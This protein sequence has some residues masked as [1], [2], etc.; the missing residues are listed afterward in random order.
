MLFTALWLAAQV[1]QPQPTWRPIEGF[2]DLAGFDKVEH[3][4]ANVVIVDA[5]WAAAAVADAPLWLRV[6]AG[7]GAGAVVSVGKE[8]WDLT[9]HGDPSLG[10]LAYDTLGIGAGVGFALA[11]EAVWRRVGA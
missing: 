2:E 9:G 7:A 1:S 8:A 10:D 5:V 11:A 4:G 3:F 6:V